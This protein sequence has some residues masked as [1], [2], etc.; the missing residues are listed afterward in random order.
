MFYVIE[1]E[2]SVSSQQ[3]NEQNM[4]SLSPLVSYVH[5]VTHTEY[6]IIN[7]PVKSLVLPHNLCILV[8]GLNRLRARETSKKFPQVVRSGND[9]LLETEARSLQ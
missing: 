2:P 3:E 6:N 5:H 1:S 8:V 4:N 9:E 7:N